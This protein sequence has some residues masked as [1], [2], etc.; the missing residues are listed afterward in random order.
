MK[1][2]IQNSLSLLAIIK[3]TCTVTPSGRG[4]QERHDQ[5]LFPISRR[6]RIQL[7]AVTFTMPGKITLA[8]TGLMLHISF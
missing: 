1:H 3:N 6:I 4:K 2:G 8:D 5:P 7:A